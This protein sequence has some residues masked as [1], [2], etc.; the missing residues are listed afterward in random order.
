MKIIVNSELSG[1]YRLE[2]RGGRP[3][4]VA[5]MLP[6]QGD[7]VMNGLFYPFSE[8]SSSY[9]QLNKLPAPAGHPE[10]DG[11]S[12]SAYDPEGAA[13]FNIGAH[14]RNPKLN[15][16]NV[17]AELAIDERVANRTED[18]RETLKR[19]KSGQRIGV[20]TGLTA[21]VNKRAGTHNGDDYH[22]VVNGIVFDHVA[23]LLDE[24]PAGENTYTLNTSKL[25][26]HTNRGIVMREI[27]ITTDDLS[28]DHHKILENAARDPA[29]LV[30]TIT[31]KAT[32]EEAEEIVTNAGKH[33]VDNS[34]AEIAEYLENRSGFAAYKQSLVDKRAEKIEWVLKNSDKFEQAQLETM[35]DDVLDAVVDTVKPIN[36]HFTPSGSDGGEELDLSDLEK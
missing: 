30:Q 18:G 23:I 35:T 25:F 6:V 11:K 9:Q 12:V 36:N 34:P 29:G 28:L 33:V 26:N 19:I 3:F 14:V 10:F 31:A 8:V 15:G 2:N 27:T 20:S 5:Q 32:P 21:N 13:P 17:L 16:K 4:V 1:R 7:S 22:G 24:P